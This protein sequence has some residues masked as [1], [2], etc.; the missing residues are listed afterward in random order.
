[1][2][3]DPAA[4]G[5]ELQYECSIDIRDLVTLKDVMEDMKLGPNGGLIYC[6]EHLLENMDWFYDELKDYQDDYIIFDCPGQ[7]ELYTHLN[8]FQDFIYNIQ[9]SG[10]NICCVYCLDSLFIEEPSKFI[11]GTFMCLSAMI[12]FELPHIN[13]LT[14]YDLLPKEKRTNENIIP[15]MDDFINDLNE[16][17]P[18]FKKLNE[19][20]SRIIQDFSLVQFIPLNYNDEESMEY[21]LSNIDH[22]IQ[23]GEDLEPK[24]PKWEENEIDE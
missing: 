8:L 10:Y 20:I 15:D 24:E 13:V 4:E 5:D 3:L 9:R 21:V 7:I 16:D 6:F 18:K 17:N 12:H 19:S 11:S 1:M 22:T 23:Y 14:K 2:N